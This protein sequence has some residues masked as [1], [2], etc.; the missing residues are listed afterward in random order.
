MSI[1]VCVK[2]V[3]DSA[4][5]LRLDH[6]DGRL[7]RAGK[8]VLPAGDL[9][10][11]EAALRLREQGHGE[12]V[13]VTLGPEHAAEAVLK[14][15]AMGADRV[16]Q[17]TDD[18]FAGADVVVTAHALAG[19]LGREEPSVVLFGQR[20][21]DGGGGALAAAVAEALGLPVVSRVR[22]LIVAGDVAVL[23]RETESGLEQVRA[24]LPAVVAVSDA[25]AEP[26]LPAMQDIMAARSKPGVVLRATDVGGAPSSL[27]TVI[28]MAPAEPDDRVM[29]SG[30]EA[31]AEAIAGFL[32]VKGLL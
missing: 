12:V 6:G 9:V 28:G 14:A 8:L 30:T 1:A 7:V 20:S 23:V 26:R 15:L 19:A 22:D 11:V 4:T 5:A 17:I 27:T 32:Q 25:F 3:P 21:P 31:T 16:V 24:P 2:A 18:A 29:I 10:A 13:V